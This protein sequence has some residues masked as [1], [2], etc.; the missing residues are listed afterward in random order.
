MLHPNLDAQKIG[1]HRAMK[2]SINHSAVHQS[3]CVIVYVS[4]KE[5][6]R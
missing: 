6:K 5:C 3:Q 1:L 4:I 2:A